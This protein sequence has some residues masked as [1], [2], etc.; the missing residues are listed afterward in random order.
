VLLSNIFQYRS[1]RQTHRWQFWLDAGSSL[2][3][4]GGTAELFG[5][6]LFVQNWTGERLTE[7]FELR[8]NDWRL[9]CVLGDLVARARDQIV[10]CH[11]DLDTNGAERLGPLLPLVDASSAWVR[12]SSTG[13]L[14]P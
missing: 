8:A 1:T 11:S 5:A 6:P 7:A 10:L 4:Q 14:V 9:R 2:W 13:T 12:S 3:A